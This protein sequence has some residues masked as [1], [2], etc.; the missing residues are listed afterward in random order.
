L[1]YAGKIVNLVCGTLAT[2]TKMT[3]QLTFLLTVFLALTA[4]NN[5]TDNSSSTTS[6]DAVQQTT[7]KQETVT[8]QDNTEKQVRPSDCTRGT[9]EPVVKKDIFPKTTFKLQTD[10]LTA[11]ETVDFDNG[12]KLII[13]NAGCE[14]YVLTFRFETTRF[15]NDT[16][17]SKYWFDK[18]IQLINETAKGI[19]APVA[20]DNGITALTAYSNKTDTPKFREEID[21]GETEIR[22][23]V[24][25]DRVE[26]MSDKKY[27]VE[28][29]FAVGPL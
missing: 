25:V 29:T 9:P 10:S 28:L 20:L 23:F 7:A 24:T 19:D 2:I 11:Y 26:K 21:Y 15:Q 22:N 4:C 1:L 16:T 6:T 5:S 27:A 13:E 17:N 18:A 12:D 8:P 14:Y 3:R